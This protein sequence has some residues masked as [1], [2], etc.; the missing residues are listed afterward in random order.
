MTINKLDY[1][2]AATVNITGIDIDILIINMEI[3]TAA[4]SQG[5][6]RAN[7]LLGYRL[8]GRIRFSNDWKSIGDVVN[9]IGVQITSEG[10]SQYD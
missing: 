6:I 2:I 8:P 3:P 9:H 1:M 5:V 4:G 10:I 7:K